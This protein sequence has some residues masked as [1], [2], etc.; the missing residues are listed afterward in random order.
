MTKP[1]MWLCRQ[2][3]L[4]SAWASAQSDQSLRCLHEDSL[5]PQLSIE[6]TADLSLCWAHTH[7]VGFITRRLILCLSHLPPQIYSITWS[8]DSRLKWYQTWMFC[9]QVTEKLDH[10]MYFS[11]APR[12]FKTLASFNL[13]GCKPWRQVFLWHGS[14]IIL[15]LWSLRKNKTKGTVFYKQI[16]LFY[17]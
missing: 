2:R 13:P 1:T 15:K 7:F 17:F 12:N 8:K 9:S 6:R 3:R 4:R 16:S 11:N 10:A 5:S 14:V